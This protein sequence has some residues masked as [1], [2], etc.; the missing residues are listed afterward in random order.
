MIAREI[1][2]TRGKVAL[3]DE[4]NYELASAA[5]GRRQRLLG[6]ACLTVAWCDGNEGIF[7]GWDSMKGVPP[8][9]D[10]G[11]NPSAGL[12]RTLDPKFQEIFLSVWYERGNI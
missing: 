11:L 6:P 5:N 12:T 7:A 1:P 8:I 2:L 9:N 4:Q 10:L 3:V